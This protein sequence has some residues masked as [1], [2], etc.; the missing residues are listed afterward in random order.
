MTTSKKIAERANN[1][2]GYERHNIVSNSSN[3]LW[4]VLFVNVT[5]SI[6]E[7]YE[8]CEEEGEREEEEEEVGDGPAAQ[9]CREVTEV[10]ERSANDFR[11]LIDRFEQ[12][13]AFYRQQL[14]QS[15]EDPPSSDESGPG[16]RSGLGPTSSS[17]IALSSGGGPVGRTGGISWEVRKP[18]LSPTSSFS[19]AVHTTTEVRVTLCRSYLCFVF[20]LSVFHLLYIIY[21][22]NLVQQENSNSPNVGEKQRFSPSKPDRSR[23]GGRAARQG[24][25]GIHQGQKKGS[26]ALRASA[27]TFQPGSGTKS[28][29]SIDTSSESKDSMV[30]SMSSQSETSISCA[31]QPGPAGRAAAA[32]VAAFPIAEVAAAEAKHPTQLQSCSDVGPRRGKEGGGGTEPRA[33][34][35]ASAR[36]GQGGTAGKGTGAGAGAG[37]APEGPDRRWLESDSKDDWDAAVQ[38]EVGGWVGVQL[39]MQMVPACFIRKSC[40]SSVIST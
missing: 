9:R 14:L 28:T 23:G 7:L 38:A 18:T 20:Q 12:Q 8:H 36:Q 16:P 13:R 19:A 31:P 29:L 4:R 6:D 34:A 1:V 21:Y 15:R 33:T 2:A 39:H 37:R 35:T 11:Q 30:I 32:V 40:F 22:N 24:G 10:L 3:K 25:D 27:P 26:S 5:R 17:A